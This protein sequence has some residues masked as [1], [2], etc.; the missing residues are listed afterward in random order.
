MGREESNRGR[1][2]NSRIVIGDSETVEEGEVKITAL[3][4][5]GREEKRLWKMNWG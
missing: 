1:A 2:V 3:V 5:G 4:Y